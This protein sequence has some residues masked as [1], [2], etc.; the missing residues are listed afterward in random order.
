MY[1]IR[2]LANPPS[3]SNNPAHPYRYP[4]RYHHPDFYRGDTS[5]DNGGVHTNS[6][7]PNKAAYLTAMGGTFNGYTITGLGLAKVEQIWYRALTTYYANS[8]TFNGAYVAL[9]QA[10]ADLYPPADLAELTKALQAVEMD[11]PPLPAP[12]FV[13]TALT[14]ASLGQPGAT[15]TVRWNSH[16][17]QTCRIRTS[18]DLATWTDV[19]PTVPAPAPVNGRLFYRV[20]Q[21]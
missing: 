21:N 19:N 11:Q 16:A 2:S 4:D 5:Y 6:S 13:I 20:E 7:V 3:V 14:A 8:E 15:A 12:P 1:A 18:T 9:R 17:G 10:C